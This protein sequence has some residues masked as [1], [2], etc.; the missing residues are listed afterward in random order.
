M[1]LILAISPI[2][3]AQINDGT[4][5]ISILKGQ[6]YIDTIESNNPLAPIIVENCFASAINIGNKKRQVTIASPQSNPNYVGT[7]KAY[8]QYTDGLKPRY[9]S[10]EIN[11]VES[12]IATNEDFVVFNST[13]TI[14]VLP[15]LND[16]T[17]ANGLKLVGLGNVQG[18]NAW[19]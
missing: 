4:K 1:I 6:T 8:T 18:G 12:K 19:Y 16:I 3:S 13:D 17:T 10:W 15:L 11:F 9:I 5:Y 14:E 2:L 7:A